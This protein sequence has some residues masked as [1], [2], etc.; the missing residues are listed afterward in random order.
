MNI[1]NL[2][3]VSA[4]FSLPHVLQIQIEPSVLIDPLIDGPIDIEKRFAIE[5]P[6]M[7]DK[8]E[9]EDF[10]LIIGTSADAGA[11][12]TQLNIVVSLLLGISLKRSWIVLNIL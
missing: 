11:V 2:K 6:R 12:G 1:Q 3:A 8:D 4:V 10:Q 5:L 9:A 7:L